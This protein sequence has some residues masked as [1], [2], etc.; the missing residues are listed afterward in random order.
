MYMTIDINKARR[1]LDALSQERQ[2][3]Q[4]RLQRAAETKGKLK[5]QTP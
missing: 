2:A 5:R 3:Q 4:D 1:A